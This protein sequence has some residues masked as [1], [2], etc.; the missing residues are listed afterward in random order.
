LTNV[1]FLAPAKLFCASASAVKSHFSS[2]KSAA[3]VVKYRLMERPELSLAGVKAQV[4]AWL[5]A[6]SGSA[7][8]VLIAEMLRT[9]LRLADDGTSRGDLK[10]LN[11][12]LKE[13]RYAFKLFAPYSAVRKVSIFGS[14]RVPESDPYYLLASELGSRLA[15]EGFMVITGAG[16]GVMQA[17]HE[18]AGQDKSFGV[19]IRL[20]LPQKAN[21]FIRDDPKLMNFH[22]FSPAS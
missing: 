19:N 9:V 15:Q 7:N 11:R 13:L 12:S 20:P 1:G 17:G 6:Q 8:E 18:G 5:Q 21:R 14:T 4:D 22:F 16:P 2:L 10:I 3:H